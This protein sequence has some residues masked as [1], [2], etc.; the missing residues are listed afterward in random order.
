VKFNKQYATVFAVI[1]LIV[2]AVMIATS[3]SAGTT[4]WSGTLT[5]GDPTWNRPNCAGVTSGIEWYDVQEFWVD[6]DGSYTIEITNLTA[7]LDDPYYLLY[8]NSFD[9]GNPTANCIAD[10]DDSGTYSGYASA[11]TGNLTANTQYVLVT[12]QCC[13]GTTVGSDDGGYT[14]TITGP[15]TITL[16]TF[17]PPALPAAPAVPAVEPPDGR[18]NRWYGDFTAVLYRNWDSEGNPA[19]VV[20]CYNGETAWLGM[21]VSAANMSDGLSA[22]V[23]DAEFYILPDGGYQ[24]NIMQDG[25]R[26]EIECAD[27]T[28]SKPEL[29]SFDAVE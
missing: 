21:Q 8:I 15:G 7:G 6:A 4:S 24:F 1:I 19:I 17:P 16:G 26:Y 27:F 2:S 20:Y 10:D 25:K 29:R 22:D 28:C 3:V 18:L 23:C 12:T 13:D 14:N 11:I 5:A 9:P